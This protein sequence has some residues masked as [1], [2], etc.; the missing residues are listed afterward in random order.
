VTRA[1][2]YID[3]VRGL[4]GVYDEG[5]EGR[6]AVDQL[7]H[8]VQMA[9]RILHTNGNRRKAA[10]AVLHDAFRVLSPLN[11]GPALAAALSDVLTPEECDILEHHSEFQHDIVHGTN[12]AQRQFGNRAWY[13]EAYLFGQLDGASFD[14][15]YTSAP[16]D[17]FI[18]M[19]QELFG[20][21]T[22]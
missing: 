9:T 20:N 2:I 7:E 16:L 12:F 18:P 11:H 8:S 3:L 22:E 10:L 17:Y 15:K 14:P 5:P 19:I 1:D 21:G 4:E 6:D 13:G